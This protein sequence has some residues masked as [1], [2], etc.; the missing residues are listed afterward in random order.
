M[1]DGLKMEKNQQE[2]NS[3]DVKCPTED[4]ISAETIGI[5][6]EEKTNTK[7]TKRNIKESFWR[8]RQRRKCWIGWHRPRVWG[9]T[10]EKDETFEYFYNCE[11]CKDDG[12]WAPPFNYNPDI[13]E[14][15]KY[16]FSE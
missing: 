3:Q 5:E 11:V 8:W 15:T 2:L 9:H 13:G 7:V 1:M 6:S 10:K 12:F 16:V 4:V 14:T